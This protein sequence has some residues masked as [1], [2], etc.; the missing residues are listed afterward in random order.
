M[1]RPGELV[2]AEKHQANESGLEEERH[3]P[4]DGERR[5][6]DIADIL[7][8]IGPVRA[9]LE[10]HG[11]AGRDAQHEVD[12]EQV[13]PEFRNSLPDF[14]SCH[15]V[16][17]FGDHEDHRKAQRQWNEQEVIERCERELP[18]GQIGNQK[19]RCHRN[20][21]RLVRLLCRISETYN[22]D[23]GAV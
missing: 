16:C 4:F 11:D 8:V 23:T 1:G 3:Q 18:A 6:E 13:G 9:E 10:L 19:I 14:L 22:I 12:A 17:A 15:D 20:L 5:P 7:G 2:P 21:V